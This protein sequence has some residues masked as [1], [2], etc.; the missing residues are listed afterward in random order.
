MSPLSSGASG[1]LRGWRRYSSFPGVVGSRLVGVAVELDGLGLVDG[2][3]EAFL[4]IERNG[5]LS[6][7]EHT[8]SQ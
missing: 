8:I 3:V 1:G 5:G 2:G 4:V 6:F 7:T